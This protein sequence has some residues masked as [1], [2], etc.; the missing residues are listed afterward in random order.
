VIIEKINCVTSYRKTV[1]GSEL[2]HICRLSMTTA[3]LL[4]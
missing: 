3:G 1:T 2:E 4:E